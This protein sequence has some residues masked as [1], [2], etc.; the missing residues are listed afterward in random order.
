MFNVFTPQQW[1]QQTG[2]PPMGN[3]PQAMQGG[4][5]GPQAMGS[6]MNGQN[7]M[8]MPQM[9]GMQQPAI[10]TDGRHE[11]HGHDGD[12]GWPAD[13][14]AGRT[15][16]RATG[17]DAPAADEPGRHAADADDGSGNAPENGL[18]MKCHNGVYR[19]T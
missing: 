15:G 2:Q 8:A 1:G 11:P 3:G 4:M 6:P 19:I 18:L 5:N 7:A 17:N 16:C 14:G 13:D 9:G 12:A 10:P